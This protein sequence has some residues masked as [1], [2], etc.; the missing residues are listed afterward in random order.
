MKEILKY[1]DIL[2]LKRL[3]RQ[4]LDLI[5]I[6]LFIVVSI[7]F[8]YHEIMFKRP[9]GV[10]VWR[11]TDCAS[12]ALNYYQKDLPLLKPQMHFRFNVKAEAMGEFPL[13]YYI[14]GK[15]YSIFGYHDA[16]YR[17]FWYLIAFLGSFCLYRLSLDALKL[18][19]ESLLIGMTLLFSPVVGYY[20]INFLPDPV[21]L[22]L[23]SVSTYLLY[24]SYRKNNLF[25]FYSSLTV[26]AFAGLF[27]INSIL[28]PLVLLG[29]YFLKSILEKDWKPSIHIIVGICAIVLINFSWYNYVIEFNAQNNTAYFLTGT[30]PIWNMDEQGKSELISI[31]I[32]RRLPEFYNNL[33][34]GFTL[35][36]VVIGLVFIKQRIWWLLFTL[37]CLIGQLL[38][39]LLFFDRFKYHDYYMINNVFILP[40]LLILS[41][42]GIKNI[43][44][45]KYFGLLIKVVLLFVMIHSA[46][47]SANFVKRRYINPEN[48]FYISRGYSTIEPYLNEKGI[49][50]DD[51][52]ISIPDDSPNTTL[53]LM[54]RSGW[55]NLFHHPMEA[56]DIEMHIKMGAKY[57]IIGD[58][59][60][61][62]DAQ[63]ARFL[64]KPIGK[65]KEIFLFEL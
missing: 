21:A 65:Y 43:S 44:M 47:M 57:L 38:F 20:A 34:L 14:V 19:F 10:H 1:S 64:Q 26:I 51:Y 18:P 13:M 53:Y 59:A 6:G 54:N 8:N 5:F 55:T 12:M 48:E 35:V 16:V 49:G 30:A 63:M 7:S 50:L 46:V 39:V 41:F 9:Q 36:M 31:L 25:I 29:T 27:K 62:K 56:D 45:P 24:L 32:D 61:L 60:L 40:F 3:P 28:I 2:S 33:F 42:Y 22:F 11:Q 37:L 17:M 15:L 58:E 52:V 23:V 4:T